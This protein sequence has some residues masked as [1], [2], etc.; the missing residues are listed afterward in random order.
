MYISYP[1]AAL[2][3][4]TGCP[5]CLISQA[6]AEDRDTGLGTW[7]QHSYGSPLTVISRLPTSAGLHNAGTC[8]LLDV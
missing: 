8:S 5:R 7:G 3:T 4:R 2:V 6:P 1:Q